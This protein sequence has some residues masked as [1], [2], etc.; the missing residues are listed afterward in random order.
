MNDRNHKD[1]ADERIIPV[2]EEQVTVGKRAVEGRTVSVTTRPVA[3][4]QR[5]AEPVIRENVT[6]ERVPVGE[7]VDAIPEIREDGDLTVIPVIEERVVV[8]K[9]L[10][11]K[12]EIHLRRTREQTTEESTVELRRTEVEITS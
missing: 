6:I 5:I 11:L 4:T 1:A 7:V 9:Q 8:T 12:E 2:V 3:E 10:V